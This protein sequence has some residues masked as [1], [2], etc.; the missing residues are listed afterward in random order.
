MN[1]LTLSQHRVKYHLHIVTPLL[2]SY[3]TFV[4]PI[5]NFAQISEDCHEIPGTKLSRLTEKLAKWGLQRQI[6]IDFSLP[7]AL[8]RRHLINQLLK[9]IWLV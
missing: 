3:Q 1:K 7:K 9:N 2:Q 4:D 8:N 6:E 5:T